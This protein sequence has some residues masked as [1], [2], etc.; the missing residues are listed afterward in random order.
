MEPT[1]L[2][3]IRGYFEDILQ[4]SGS[5]VS[6]AEL[7]SYASAVDSGA[8]T[9]DQ[10]R[11]ALINSPE[12]EAVQDVVRLYQVV[13]GRVPDQAGLNFQVDALRQANISIEDVA[14]GFAASD[15]FESFFGSNEVDV[16]FI[17]AVYLNTFGRIPSASEVQFYLDSGFS[18]GRIALAFSESPEFL[19]TSQDAVEQFLDE[20][21]QGTQDY[22]GSLFEGGTNNPGNIFNF[23][24]TAGE[25]VTGTAGDD[26][27]TGV[28]GNGTN[29][30]VQ[31]GDTLNGGAGRDTL[32]LFTIADSAA[33]LPAGV[34][35]SGVEVINLNDAPG[36]GT[37]AVGGVIDASVFGADAEEIWQIGNEEGISNLTAGQTVGYRNTL[38]DNAA[39]YVASATAATVALDNVADGSAVTVAGAGLTSATVTGSVDTSAVPAGS[40]GANLTIDVDNDSAASNADVTTLNL[41]LST[42]TELTIAAAGAAEIETFDASG[43]TGGIRIILPVT[44]SV[45]AISDASFGSGND[46]V[47]ASMNSFTA[48]AVTVDL[49]A[50]NDRLT[51]VA[52]TAGDATTGTI[53]LGAGDDVLVLSGSN[54]GD[55]PTAATLVSNLISVT[56]FSNANDV[57]DLSAYASAT[58]DGFFTQ[59]A[60]NAAVDQSAT[61]LANVTAVAATIGAGEAAQFTF[62]GNVYVYVNNAD[63]ALDGGD[64]LVELTGAT[65]LLTSDSVQF[66]AV[67]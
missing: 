17:N 45:L 26:T 53:T 66:T 34:Q 14:N 54:I 62:D 23:T 1:T 32:N 67:A 33:G 28:V 6:N 41:N 38:I 48:E 19:G 60:V 13:F 31:F 18:A 35:I 21:G 59:N 11:A 12:G 30:T 10:A 24:A 20:A 5:E 25:T 36:G 64:L 15:E 61:L 39:T 7:Q 49:G 29:G 65:S 56:D 40:F 47:Q 44:D 4:R 37:Y 3:I 55:A 16:P 9:L 22:E 27:F 63:A 2:E 51:L 58:L 57:L 46:V 52:S 43:S 42:N 50:G 8:L